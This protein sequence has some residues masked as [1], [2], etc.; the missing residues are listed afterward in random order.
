MAKPDPSEANPTPMSSVAPKE[1]SRHAIWP[2][3]VV[4]L[5]TLAVFL[6]LRSCQ[7]SAQR[8]AQIGTVAGL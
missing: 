2:W 3:I 6:S 8:S 5:V 4:P 7:L 1:P